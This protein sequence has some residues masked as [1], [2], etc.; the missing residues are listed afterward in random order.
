MSVY[1]TPGYDYAKGTNALT[2]GHAQKQASQEYG[3][4]L[5]QQRFRRQ[6]GDMG[7]QFQQ[8]LPKVG[9]HFGSRGI[10][11]SGLRQEGTRK[12]AQDYQRD[13]QRGQQDQAQRE[14]GY[15]LSDSQDTADLNAALLD[16]FERY[17]ASGAT[18]DAFK[19]II[20]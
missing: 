8:G 7:R 10:Y 14:Q 5:G 15:A 12:Y 4:F 18:D 9:E 19:Q 1:G 6:Q 11:R 13:L 3:R 20:I 17:K 2:T 16:L